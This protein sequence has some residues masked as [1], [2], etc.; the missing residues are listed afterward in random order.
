MVTQ[1]SNNNF[2]AVAGDDDGQGPSLLAVAGRVDAD[3][4]AEHQV[5]AEPSGHADQRCPRDLEREHAGGTAAVRAP[6]SANAIPN[7]L[8]MPSASD[9]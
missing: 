6:R 2:S 7:R 8:S 5:A 1:A 3:A 4:V 9:A